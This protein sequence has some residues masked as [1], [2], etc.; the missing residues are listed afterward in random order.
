LEVHFIGQEVAMTRRKPHDAKLQALRGQGAVNPRWDAVA[1]ELFGTHEFFD[2]RDL[3]QVKYEMLRRVQLEGHTVTRAATAFGFSRLSFYQARSA[4]AEQGLAGLV[5]RKRGP[6]G[7]HKLTNEVIGFLE[8]A[9]AKDASL[10]AP[11]MVE[12]V[13]KRFQV[14]IHPR[15]IE[16]ALA[17]REK[18]RN[19]AGRTRT[20]HA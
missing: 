4:F 3:V 6:R 20:G 8:Q 11:E 12:L 2:A 17:R 15:T 14:Q 19:R 7:P 9:R 10:R 16:R 1:D 18:K 13:S 5:P